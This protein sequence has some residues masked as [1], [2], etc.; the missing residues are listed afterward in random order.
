MTSALV[1]LSGGADSTFSLF[2]T[3]NRYDKVHTVTFDYDQKHSIEIAAA[4]TIAKL[5]GVQTHEVINLHKCLKST[6][7]LVDPHSDLE[8]YPDFKTMTDIIGDRVEL[9][10][11]PMRNTLFLTIAANRAIDLGCK[12]IVT[13]VCQADGAN[14]ADTTADFIASMQ[15]LL[16]VST[17]QEDYLIETPLMYRTKAQS[18][19]EALRYEGCYTALAYS[20][21]AY[22]GEYPPV[23]QDHATVLRAEGF[24]QSGYPDPLIVRA[25]WEH[26]LDRLPD[27]PNYVKYEARLRRN[28]F[29][30][31]DPKLV[32]YRLHN[33]EL[34]F[35]TPL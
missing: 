17:G 26:K 1:V 11:V 10:F 22:S 3:K 13:G 30:L 15:H 24:R 4:C 23:T 33:L 19:K 8:T 31:D 25:Y 29:D 27:T 2:W 21:T 12:A 5:A 16:N 14:Y 6:S 9:T 28:N 18:V 7:P 32:E 20:H 34:Y 35:R